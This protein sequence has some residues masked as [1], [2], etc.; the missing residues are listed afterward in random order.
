MLKKNYLA[1]APSMRPLKLTLECLKARVR[2]S[3]RHSQNGRWFAPLA[4]Q[5]RG[6]RHLRE[7]YKGTLYNAGMAAAAT[8]WT[9]L[10]TGV[11]QRED[12]AL[13]TS[14]A[15]AIFGGTR[16]NRLCTLLTWLVCA[17]DR[18]W[19]RAHLAGSDFGLHIAGAN[20]SI[21]LHGSAVEAWEAWVI[22]TA[23]AANRSVTEVA[24]KMQYTSERAAAQLTFAALQFDT[25]VGGGHMCIHRHFGMVE[26]YRLLLACRLDY[27]HV[28][29]THTTVADLCAHLA[30]LFGMCVRQIAA[31]SRVPHI[32]RQS[33]VGY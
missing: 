22:P 27:S 14:T 1:T 11:E 12:Y 17:W 28:T 24:F 6:V 16:H 21:H 15:T 32:A 5:M 30:S 20:T 3:A 18:A 25:A 8:K 2:H 9:E 19:V 26:R 31:G 13:E 4:T 33:A 29:R 10:S 23:V 7:S